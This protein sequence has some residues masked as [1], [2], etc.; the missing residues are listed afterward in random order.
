MTKSWVPKFS[1]FRC[2]DSRVTSYAASFQRIPPFWFI[3]SKEHLSPQLK[4][5]GKLCATRK[6]SFLCYT[7]VAGY[8]QSTK[9]LWRMSSFWRGVAFLGLILPCYSNFIQG[10]SLQFKKLCLEN[11]RRSRKL[12]EILFLHTG[13]LPKSVLI[14]HGRSHA[15]LMKFSSCW[16]KKISARKSPVIFMRCACLRRCSWTSIYHN[17]EKMQRGH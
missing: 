10:F 8:S 2:L 5:L 4:L 3:A 11:Q 16:N 12:D 14:H 6:I 13:T 7:D 1:S 9:G 17:S 15:F